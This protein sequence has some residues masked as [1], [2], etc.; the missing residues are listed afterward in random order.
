VEGF[1]GEIHSGSAG[2]SEAGGDAFGDLPA[3]FAQWL[4]GQGSADEDQHGSPAG[5]GFVDGPEV[6]L[7]GKPAGLG[8]GGGEEPCAGE[9]AALHPSVPDHAAGL[10]WIR[11]SKVIA[12]QSDTAHPCGGVGVHAFAQR[13]RFRGDR[14]DGQFGEFAVHATVP[15]LRDGTGKR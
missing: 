14:V 7:D 5:G 2:V 15:R 3:A 4:T 11:F 8:G 1:D 12:P 6:I 13:P 10:R 9:S